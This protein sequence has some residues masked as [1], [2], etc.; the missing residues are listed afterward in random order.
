M[1][2]SLSAP[3]HGGQARFDW[4]LRR[5]RSTFFR[6]IAYTHVRLFALKANKANTEVA[7]QTGGGGGDKAHEERC[8]SEIFNFSHAGAQPKR[9]HGQG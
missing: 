8:E 3:I 2:L 5:T 7:E 1:Y 4:A 6:I 9:G